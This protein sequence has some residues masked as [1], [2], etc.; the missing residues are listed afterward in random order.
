MDLQKLFKGIAVVIDDDIDEEESPISKI[1]EEIENDYHIR[2]LKL[3]E[4]PEENSI[5]A[6]SEAVI[7]I[8]DWLLTP[9]SS[10]KVSELG[11]QPGAALNQNNDDLKIDLIEQFLHKSFAPIFVL[12]DNPPVAQNVL[13]NS[14]VEA[15]VG[16]RIIVESKSRVQGAQQIQQFLQGWL[17]KNHESYVLKEWEVKAEE[18]KHDFFQAFG[19]DD[20][21]WV[22]ALWERLKIDDDAECSNMLGEYLTRCIVNNMEDI[23][24]DDSILNNK[25]QSI[26]SGN[27][28]IKK[29]VNI[30]TIKWSKK[31]L[32]PDH[33]HA[34][35][36]FYST[37]GDHHKF[38]LS[39]RADCDYSRNTGKD[40]FYLKGQP[41]FREEL[42]K[43]KSKIDKSGVIYFAPRKDLDTSNVDPELTGNLISLGC[44][45]KHLDKEQD[46]DYINKLLNPIP[47]IINAYG[48]LLGQRN[49]FYLPISCPKSYSDDNFDELNDMIAI[50][51]TFDLLT[52]KFRTVHNNCISNDR[53]RSGAISYRYMGKLLAPYINEIQDE[54]AQWIFR[55]GAMP[56]PDEFYD[57]SY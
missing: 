37:D 9:I 22:D 40:L 24:F 52:I 10:Q 2:F 35:D 21:S 26:A 17:M 54:C 43:D 42:E 25:K 18:A 33:P 56:T 57:Q 31:G 50:K 6:F 1:I 27:E 34:G 55:T 16:G 49:Q 53:N 8:L 23:D 20:V 19:P 30:Q 4:L 36:I 38:M 15:Y 47:K 51:F 48:K 7:I 29:L 32:C 5:E 44:I 41:L 12:T 45:S 11:V 3:D 39:I 46:L 14:K 28:A 13:Q